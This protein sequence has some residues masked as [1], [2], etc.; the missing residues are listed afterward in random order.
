MTRW[1]RLGQTV[2]VAIAR[3]EDGATAPILGEVEDVPDEDTVLVRSAHPLDR[4]GRRLKWF[5]S[6]DL[7]RIQ[8]EHP[9]G[10][11]GGT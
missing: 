2:T 4:D 5:R 1:F 11:L 3:N 6:E 10:M 8:I 7:R 9:P